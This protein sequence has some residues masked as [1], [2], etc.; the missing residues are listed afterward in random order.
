MD[1]QLTLVRVHEPD[2]VR[3]I[4]LDALNIAQSVT[5]DDR[6]REVVFVEACRLLGERV[7]I[8]PQPMPIPSGFILPDSLRTG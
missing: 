1:V 4:L 5:T 7:P 8:M 2:A 3:A 6:E